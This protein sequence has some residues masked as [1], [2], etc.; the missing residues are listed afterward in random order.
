MKKTKKTTISNKPQDYRP[1]QII[2][3]NDKAVVAQ[4][5]RRSDAM[6]DLQKYERLVKDFQFK[7]KFQP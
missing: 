1:W 3:A 2:R 6:A 7:L 5:H 4:Y